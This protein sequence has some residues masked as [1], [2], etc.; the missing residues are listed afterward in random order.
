MNWR[1][2]PVVHFF[3]EALRFVGLRDRL[4]CPKCSAV[5][6]WKPHGGILTFVESIPH[7]GQHIAKPER[8][9]ATI[10]LCAPL[11]RT[12]HTDTP[13]HKP[14]IDLACLRCQGELALEADGVRKAE[15]QKAGIE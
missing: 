12:T 4:R 7:G 2:N 9:Y 1:L 13:L 8:Y 10:D 15:D 3:F 14:G 5:G 11:Q 6:T